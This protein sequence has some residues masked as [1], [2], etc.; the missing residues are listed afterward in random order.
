M[1][2]KSFPTTSGSR[3]RERAVVVVVVVVVCGKKKIT[4][5]FK[6]QM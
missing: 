3:D 5:G 1:C 4:W 6:Y 2:N